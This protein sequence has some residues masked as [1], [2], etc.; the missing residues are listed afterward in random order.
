[1]ENNYNHRKCYR[2]DKLNIPAT[3]KTMKDKVYDT[4]IEDMS[5]TGMR[6]KVPKDFTYDGNTIFV[7]FAMPDTQTTLL[8]ACKVVHHNTDN[9]GM[10]I[11]TVLETNPKILNQQRRFPS[12]I[13]RFIT[14]EQCRR[15]G[16][17]NFVRRKI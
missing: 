6:I 16:E 3:I 1:M 5:I 8:L 17:N 9:I 7:S 15:I 4:I 2:L 10:Y 13:A 14:K 11:T 12:M